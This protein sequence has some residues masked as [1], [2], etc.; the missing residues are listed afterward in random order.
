MFIV[1]T[2]DQIYKPQYLERAPFAI[3]MIVCKEEVC[4]LE[5]LDSILS[6]LGL[7]IVYTL[8]VF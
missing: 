6:K 3:F 8:D 5:Q 1:D 7:N 2:S 4:I